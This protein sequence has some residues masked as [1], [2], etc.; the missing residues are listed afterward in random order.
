MWMNI[1]NCTAIV[2]GGNRGIGEGFV[3]ELLEQGKLT[4]KDALQ[5][6]Q[7]ELKA[8][9]RLKPNAIRYRNETDIDHLQRS[10]PT[11]ALRPDASIR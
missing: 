11:Q 9:P 5:T 7:D 4:F 10:C 1:E 3:E 6:Y 2:T 8:N